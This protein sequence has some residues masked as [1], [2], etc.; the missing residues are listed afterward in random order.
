MQFE[1]PKMGKSST[2]TYFVLE[3][4]FPEPFS[5][6]AGRFL[7]PLLAERFPKASHGNPRLCSVFVHGTC[8]KCENVTI[9]RPEDSI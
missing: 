5:G 7:S 4:F 1:V 6:A 3:S 9:A 8:D 2:A